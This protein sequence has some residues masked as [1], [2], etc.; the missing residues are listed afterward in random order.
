MKIYTK[1][2]DS[3]ETGLLAGGRVSKDNARI[4]AYGTIDELNAALGL[5]RS[6][7]LPPEVEQTLE[8]VQNELFAVGAE[9][10]TPEAER[11][12]LTLLNE[13]HTELLE[14]DI[15]NLEAGLPPLKNF[16]LPAGSRAACL[17]HLARGLCRRGERRIVALAANPQTPVSPRILIYV[18][19]LSDYLFVAARF[20]NVQ[21]HTEEVIWRMPRMPAAQ[22]GS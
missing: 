16:I 20:V 22:D 15:D 14:R 4:E 3:G 6:E 5:V 9:L 19:R 12:G 7:R 8:R 13:Q 2:G 11:H 21:S 10:A 17:L 1:T 18:N